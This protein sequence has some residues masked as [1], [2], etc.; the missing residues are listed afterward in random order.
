MKIKDITG[1]LE[2]IAHPFLQE[3]YDN[4][5]LTIGS[6]DSNLEKVLLCLDVNEDVVDEAIQK[7]C[8]LIISHHPVIFKGLK[9]LNGNTENE[10][11]IIKAI[12]N[13]IALY[14]IH[15]NIDNILSGING[16]LAEKTGL[17][18]VEILL[19]KTG[20]LRKLVTFCPIAETAKVREALFNAGAG[21]IGN[22]DSCSFNTEGNGT[23]RANENAHPFT[24]NIN[25]LH[26]EKE[27]RIETIYPVYLEKE[28]IAALLNAHPYEE[29]AYDIYTLNNEFSKT[30]SGVIGEI[31]SEIGETALFDVIKKELGIQC[32][33]HSKFTGKNIKRVAI[34]SG[35]GSF[36]I[37]EAIRKKADVFL[38]ADLK[39]HD[40]SEADGKLLLA[41]IGHFESEHIIKELLFKILTEKFNNFAV[42]ISEKD[43]NPVYYY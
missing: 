1:F 27:T 41:D 34:C 22:Y 24:G 19:P 42:L 2:S 18:N 30:G 39:Y 11:L 12:K 28:I 8:N 37:Q 26:F 33:R 43:L 36:M 3:P 13:N 16:L 21:N 9:K 35:S 4:C 10:R 40:F 20:L 14:A 17:Q 23:F 15:T 7:G 29:V 32:I 25:E 6:K 31:N 38:T 5:G